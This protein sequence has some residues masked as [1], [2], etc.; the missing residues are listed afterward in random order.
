[1][2]GSVEQRSEHKYYR[3]SKRGFATRRRCLAVGPS[4]LALSAGWRRVQIG[5][6][7]KLPS[8]D[9]HP[10]H[11]PLPQVFAADCGYRHT[12][13][14]RRRTSEEFTS[15]AS[16]R[17]RHASGSPNQS[18]TN[19]ACVMNGSRPPFPTSPSQVFGIAA[20][21]VNGGL[22]SPPLFFISLLISRHSGQYNKEGRHHKANAKK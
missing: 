8:I 22:S 1:M 19:A 14:L 16:K 18:S 12:A 7:A 15:S 10:R 3:L 6:A 11:P 20:V 9:L 13:C 5:H 21:I 4:P 17:G 2:S